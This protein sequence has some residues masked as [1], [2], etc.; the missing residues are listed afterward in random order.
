MALVCGDCF[1]CCIRQHTLY[2]IKGGT[3][4][5][6]NQQ[7]QIREVLTIY[8]DHWR[9]SGVSEGETGMLGE[10]VEEE[11][12]HATEKGKTVE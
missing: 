11:R 8:K 6:G 4:R 3:L 2:L 5:H 10:E 1:R 12:Q 9:S 7:K